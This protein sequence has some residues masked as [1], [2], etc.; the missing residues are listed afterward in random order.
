M[1]YAVKVECYEPLDKDM[2]WAWKYDRGHTVRTIVNGRELKFNGG[3]EVRGILTDSGSV[4]AGYDVMYA[5]GWLLYEFKMGV[6]EVKAGIWDILQA[7][8][9]LD[10][11][12][13]HTEEWLFRK[14]GTQDYLKIK[15]MQEEALNRDGLMKNAELEF[16]M[17]L[18][19]LEVI[20]RGFP[21]NNEGRLE[22]LKEVSKKR[23]ILVRQGAI[24]LGLDKLNINRSADIVKL[25]DKFG[26]PYDY[27][28]TAGKEWF[29][30]VRSVTGG[31]KIKN[32]KVTAVVPHNKI[33]GVRAELDRGGVQYA[34][35]PVVDKYLF[36]RYPELNV[37][38]EIK[39]MNDV[40]KKHL[41]DEN[42]R[43]V[44]K[45]RVH[46]QF[47]VTEAVSLRLSSQYPSLHQVPARGDAGGEVRKLYVPE[48]G[49]VLCKLDYG[50]IE[51]R[52]ICSIACGEGSDEVRRA[53]KENPHLDFHRYVMELTGLDRQKAKAMNFGVSFGAGVDVLSRMFSWSLSETQEI[54]DGYYKAMPFIKPTRKAVGDKAIERGYVK[55]LYKGRARLKGSHESYMMLN[56]FTQRSGAEILKCAIREAYKEGLWSRLKVHN[57]VHDE[58]DISVE[59]EEGAVRDVYKMAWIMRNALKLHE[60]P[61]EAEPEFGMNWKEVYGVDEWNKKL[62]SGEKVPE[63]IYRVMKL[64]MKVRD[65]YKD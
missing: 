36:K 56:R 41:G 16:A 19:V 29:S 13:E 54:M 48:E 42:E 22:L 17:N 23:D 53:Y 4:V 24:K 63:V 39:G 50:Q 37:I 21:Y 38:N 65:D 44:Y 27:N 51:Y 35:R 14:Y 30:A 40:I 58:F 20:Q 60:V 49:C 5:L 12:C 26:V 6:N 31:V 55:S 33:D 61:L 8:M 32:G 2:G 18:P 1:E 46:T 34:V 28:I 15:G 10:E 57:I 52:A 64:A 25:C 47:K 9:I 11:F 59:P 7:E 3:A 43:F 45:G 62:E